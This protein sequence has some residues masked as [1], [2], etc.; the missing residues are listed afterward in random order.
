MDQQATVPI[1]GASPPADQLEAGKV[2]FDSPNASASD[3]DKDGVEGVDHKG[4]SGPLA[5][6]WSVLSE[7]VS[8]EGHGVSPLS[9]EERTD[10]NFGQ[11]FTLW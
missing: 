7:K 8:L 4:A 10:P 1:S 2:P 11:N 5:R 9:V 3:V 6:V